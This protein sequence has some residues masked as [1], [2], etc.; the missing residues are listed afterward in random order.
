MD[1]ALGGVGGLGSLATAHRFVDS[2]W[3]RIVAGVLQARFSVGRLTRLRQ[4]A[5]VHTTAVGGADLAG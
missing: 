4:H 3:A 1:K 2:E 5:R